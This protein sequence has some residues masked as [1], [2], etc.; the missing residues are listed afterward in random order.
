MSIATVES[1]ADPTHRGRTGYRITGPNA[2][3]VQDA[4]NTLERTVDPACG[5]ATGMANFMGPIAVETPTGWQW[6]ALG[7]VVVDQLEFA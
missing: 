4:I 2:A 5:G 3:S 6:G 1:Q 7:E